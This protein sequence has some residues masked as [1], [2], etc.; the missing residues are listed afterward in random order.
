MGFISHRLVS[1]SPR[2]DLPQATNR[3]GK[4]NTFE[5]R[6]HQNN[7]QKVTSSVVVHT[8]F[9]FEATFTFLLKILIS[10]R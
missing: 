10:S 1:R 7:Q 8:V 9:C 6:F 3:E 5:V 2:N 4:N